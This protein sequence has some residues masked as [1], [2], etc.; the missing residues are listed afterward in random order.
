MSCGRLLGVRNGREPLMERGA[1][2]L[3]AALG[4]PVPWLKFGWS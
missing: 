3:A 2:D 4:L 1:R